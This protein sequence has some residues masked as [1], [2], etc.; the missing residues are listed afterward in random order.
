M[1]PR[2]GSRGHQAATNHAGWQYA[3]R[4]AAHAAAEIVKRGPPVGLGGR[5]VR[6]SGGG[7]RVRERYPDLAIVLPGMV[8][9]FLLDRDAY[10][11][12]LFLDLKQ[13]RGVLITL[14]AL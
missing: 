6:R 9:P 2:M 13:G 14:H 1:V 4:G 5:P 11:L 8:L 7:E 10:A 12:I 3:G